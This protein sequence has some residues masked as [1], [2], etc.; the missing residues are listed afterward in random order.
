MKIFSKNNNQTIYSKNFRVYKIVC[1]TLILAIALG[2]VCFSQKGFLTSLLAKFKPI[3]QVQKDPN[4]AFFSEIFDLI[5]NNYWDK[6]TDE[7]ALSNLYEQAIE[8]INPTVKALVSPSK[9]NIQKIIITATKNLP[10]EQKTAFIA[11]VSG[12]VLQNL[13]PFGRNQLYGEKQITDIVNEVKNTQPERN[14]YSDL[15]IGS[16]ATPGEIEIAYQTKL[17][18]LE[19]QKP[20]LEVLQ[21][22]ADLLKTFNTLN[23]IDARKTYDGSGVQST[24]SYKLINPRIFYMHITRFSPTTLQDVDRAA[25]SVDVGN[26]LDTLILDLRDN[27]G[28]LIDGLTY[29]LGPFIGNDQ[30]AYQFY[31]QGNKVDFKTTTGWLTSLTRYKKVVVLTNGG[32]QSSTEVFAATLKKYNVGVLVGTKTRGWGTLEKMELLKNQPNPKEKYTVLLVEALTLRE[33]GQA[34]EGLGVE[35]N[36]NIASVGWENELYS[37]FNSREIVSTVKELLKPEITAL[38]KK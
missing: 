28:G 8:K 19:T 7:I 11:Q 35:P 16:S 2:F 37:R 32:A 25:Q 24:V 9:E 12:L 30:Y 18:E 20:T 22:K 33:D 29:F 38:T 21:K 15:G 17:K 34:I 36:I 31:I 26:G 23:N 5:I 14:L 13:K 4:L 6:A 27:I 1:V 10:F 3:Q